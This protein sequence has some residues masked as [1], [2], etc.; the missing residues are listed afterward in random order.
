MSKD[1]MGKNSTEMVA[2][3][4]L[5]NC[6]VSGMVDDLLTAMFKAALPDL[7]REHI[8]IFKAGRWYQE[9]NSS[10]LGTA[11]VYKLQTDIHFDESDGKLPTVI[12]CLGQFDKGFLEMPDIGL[13]FL[14]VLK[15]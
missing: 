4:K 5:L 6:G 11:I 10:W 7:C 9:I 15:F 3:R 2:A 12:F 14:Y 8:E 1:L 13:R